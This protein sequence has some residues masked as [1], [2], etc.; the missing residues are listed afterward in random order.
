MPTQAYDSGNSHS[1]IQFY[2]ASFNLG[3]FD[4]EDTD[5]LI[6]LADIISRFEIV[7][8]QNIPAEVADSAFNDLVDKI[9]AYGHQYD[10]LA[11]SIFQVDMPRFAYIYRT[12]I[13]Y[14]VQW[15][16]YSGNQLDEFYQAPFIA[17]FEHNDGDFDVTL[18][19]YYENLKW[20]PDELDFLQKVINDVKENIPDESD[21]I[22]LGPA[23]TDCERP[24]S[25]ESLKSLNQDD[26]ICLINYGE[27]HN[28]LIESPTNPQIIIAA[29]SDALFWEEGELLR[30]EDTDAILNEALSSPASPPGFSGVIVVK[31]D[32][33]TKNDTETKGFCF[34]KTASS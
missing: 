6:L 34:F 12:D 21:I 20:A 28:Q 7:A 27:A 33:E 10:Y 15:Y 13:V 23:Y 30:I 32:D 25:Q 18:I 22:A 4:L 24:A 1:K 8:L 9:N 5:T 16:T 26:L 3:A 31:A 14:P 17:R 29:Y 2:I 19:N 11:D